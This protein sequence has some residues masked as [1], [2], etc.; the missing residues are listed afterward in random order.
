MM[1]GARCK[2]LLTDEQGEKITPCCQNK[3]ALRRGRGTTQGGKGDSDAYPKR[4]VPVAFFVRYSCNQTGE[5]LFPNKS[6][7]SFF[8]QTKAL[9]CSERSGALISVGVIRAFISCQLNYLI[10]YA[11]SVPMVSKPRSA[12]G[13]L[14]VCALPRAAAGLVSIDGEGRPIREENDLYREN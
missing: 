12:T 14:I 3:N 2:T 5:N 4:S 13:T 11:S 10:C 9:G 1:P 8:H 7:S 6:K